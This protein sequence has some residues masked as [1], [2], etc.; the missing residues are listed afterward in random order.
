MQ[1]VMIVGGPGS[2]KS[3]LARSLG[4]QTGL[5][6]FHMDHLHWQPGWVERARADKIAMALAVED[7]ARWIFEG[8]LSATYAHRMARADTLVWLDLP[9]VLRLWRVMK[10]TVRDFGQTRPDLPEPCPERLN[11]ETLAFWRYIWRTRQTA[12]RPLLA[13]MDAPPPH[14]RIVQLQSTAAA[15]AFLAGLPHG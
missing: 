4:A 8:N 3:T 12:R 15:G 9:V 13:V 5:P 11:Y 6:V 14:L 1:R 10:R 7:G 2:G